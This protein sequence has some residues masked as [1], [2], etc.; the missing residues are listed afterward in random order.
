VAR[1]TTIKVVAQG[2]VLKIKVRRGSRLSL[3]VK[4][5]IDELQH[6]IGHFRVLSLLQA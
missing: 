4:F 1:Q 5:I 3:P 6:G 2:L